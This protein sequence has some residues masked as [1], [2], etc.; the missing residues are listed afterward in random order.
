MK[1]NIS[2]ALSCGPAAIPPEYEKAACSLAARYVTSFSLSGLYSMDS[3]LVYNR[4]CNLVHNHLRNNPA[5]SPEAFE[6]FIN[7]NTL[8]Y[9]MDGIQ[10]VIAQYKLDPDAAFP[11]ILCFFGRKLCAFKR[12]R[13]AYMKGLDA[14][15]VDAVLVVALYKTL[16]TYDFS[17][18]FSF[19]YLDLELFAALTELGGQMHPFGMGRN[20]YVSYLKLSYLAGKYQLTKDT[21]PLFLAEINSTLEELPQNRRHFAID[22]EDLRYQC[23]MTLK[24][25]TAYFT[26]Y[27]IERLGYVTENDTSDTE[28]SAESL[29][30][31]FETGYS[32]VELELFAEQTMESERDR[33]IFHR[34][35]EPGGAV[36]KNRELTEE[37]D[38]TRY[39]LSKLK[40]RIFREIL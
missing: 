4:T 10:A 19:S 5:F 7:A 36:F 32:D 9:G 33:K 34:L 31:T 35:T 30:S 39:A 21:L 16:D 28:P 25:A 1:Q 20:D 6:D 17:S 11:Y 12:S 3:E 8:F 13:A 24:K 2:I 18:P 23:K 14:E 22:P 15:E 29:G 38:T 27:S 26:L 37:F 40:D